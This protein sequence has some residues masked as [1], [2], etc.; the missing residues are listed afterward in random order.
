MRT[1][2]SESGVNVHLHRLA[3]MIGHAMR[4]LK[5]CVL[6]YFIFLNKYS[7]HYQESICTLSFAPDIYF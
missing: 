3:F 1:P 6:F 7:G 2:A 4:L 5:L